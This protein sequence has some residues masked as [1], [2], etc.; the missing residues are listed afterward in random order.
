VQRKEEAAK[1]QNPIKQ[2]MTRQSEG[3]FL[4]VSNALFCLRHRSFGEGD[5]AIVYTASHAA[6]D[7][8][9]HATEN[10][11]PLVMVFGSV[12]GYGNLKNRVRTVADRWY[13]Q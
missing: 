8:T 3:S 13:L 6:W 11:W 12:F 9:F 5:D 10:G 7:C 4:D 1:S 2:T